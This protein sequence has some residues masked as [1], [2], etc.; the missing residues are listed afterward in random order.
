[1]DG[2]EDESVDGKIMGGWMEELGGWEDGW[3]DNRVDERMGQW[4]NRRMGVRS[5]GRW[6]NG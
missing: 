6:V 3:E 2:W 1:M 4:I 5:M